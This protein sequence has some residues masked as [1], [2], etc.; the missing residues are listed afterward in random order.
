VAVILAFTACLW[1]SAS[2]VFALVVYAEWEDRK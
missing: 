2:I 1:L